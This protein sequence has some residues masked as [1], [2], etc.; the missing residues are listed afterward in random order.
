MTMQVTMIDLAP[1]CSWRHARLMRPY[2][3]GAWTFA[4]DGAA[5]VVVPRIETVPEVAGAPS[6]AH[7]FVRAPRAWQRPP[8]INLQQRGLDLGCSVALPWGIFAQRY[9]RA[10]WA[11]P[12]VEVSAGATP[13]AAMAFRFADGEGLVM[14]LA[15]PYPRHVDAVARVLTA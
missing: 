3:I 1:F 2:S 10:I 14:P 9:V 12:E 6:L 4:A 13:L 5:A 7:L 8:T 11:L 15:S